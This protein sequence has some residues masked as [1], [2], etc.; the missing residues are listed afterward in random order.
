MKGTIVV[1]NQ[2]GGVTKTT[3][4]L[5]LGAGLA[6]QG[7][8]VLCIDL[9]PQA[10][11]T[12]ALGKEP[13]EM[14]NNICR[15]L[16]GDMPM[17]KAIYEIRENLFLVPSDLELAILEMQ[18]ISRTAREIILSK[19]IE[20]IKELFDYIIIDCPPQLSILTINGLSAADAVI[21]PVKTDYKSYKS[22]KNFLTTVEDIKGMVNP[23][24]RV[25]GILGTLHEKRNKEHTEV[26]EYIEEQYQVIG[27]IK[28]AADATKGDCDGMTVVEIKPNSEVAQQYNQVIEYIKGVR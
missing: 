6:K 14:P 15:V 27:V 11:L 12:I 2:K 1:G 19:A 17:K 24:L 18:L 28:K 22:I 9:D 8:K 13:E 16:A 23:N 5:N 10:T 26:L 7:E 25:L 20:G 21:V 3:T 4:A